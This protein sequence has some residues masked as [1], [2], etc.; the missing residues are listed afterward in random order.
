MMGSAFQF[1]ASRRV[2]PT[3][4]LILLTTITVLTKQAAAVVDFAAHVVEGFVVSERE[5]EALRTVSLRA[6]SEGC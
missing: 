4:S 1:L 3:I 6:S 5:I 2:S